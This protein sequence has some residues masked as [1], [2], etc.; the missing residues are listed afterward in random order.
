MLFG[1]LSDH[2]VLLAELGLEL[3]HPQRVVTSN[4]SVRA[5][6][7]LQ[8]LGSVLEELLQ[9]AVELRGPY[10]NLIAEVGN[11]LLV[12][13]VTTQHRHLFFPCQMLPGFLHWIP[14]SG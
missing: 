6:V 13:Q 7:A 14:P 12:D 5:T 9:P 1:Q 10:S 4:G 3:F 2:L 8:R 11:R